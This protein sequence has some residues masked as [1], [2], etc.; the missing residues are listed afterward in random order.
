MRKK[1]AEPVKPTEESPKEEPK[2]E[3][4]AP[5]HVKPDWEPFEVCTEWEDGKPVK[6][7]TWKHED[8]QTEQWRGDKRV[9][10]PEVK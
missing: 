5:L 2:A 9:Y 8:G 1:K 6:V 7:S 10:G 3:A 4:S